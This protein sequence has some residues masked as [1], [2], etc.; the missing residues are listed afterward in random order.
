MAIIKL[1]IYRHKLKALRDDTGRL[2]RM[3]VQYDPTY[4]WSHSKGTL[5]IRL[6]ERIYEIE[7]QQT[8]V[9]S[10]VTADLGGMRL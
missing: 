2:S 5:A 7:G 6:R 10:T 9:T 1:S 3:E 4:S 8:G